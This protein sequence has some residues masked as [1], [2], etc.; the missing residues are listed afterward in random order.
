MTQPSEK[1]SEKDM[2]GPQPTTARD[3]PGPPVGA[4]APGAKTVPHI[5]QPTMPQCGP[6]E[7]A[8]G[9][10]ELI[11]ELGRGGMG[12]VY[13][14]RQVELNRT[15]AVKMI[16][17]GTMS[18]PAEVERFRIE[19]EAMARLQHANIV[20]VFEVGEV[21]GRAYYSMEYID[22]PSLA[23]KVTDGPLPGR[24]AARCLAIIARALHH[25]HRNGILH[26]DLKPSNILLD[27]EGMPHI[28]D[29]GLAKKLDTDSGQTRTG[30]VMGTPSYMPPEQAAGRVR[31]LGPRSDVYS[32]GAVLY[33]S[34]T[35]R[36]PFRAETALDTLLQVLERQAA[37][38]RL[39]NAK[40]DRDLET[41]CMKCLE[42]NPGDRYESAEA[43]AADLER[44]LRGESIA[45]RTFNVL[46][47][48][49]RTLERDHYLGEF[50]AWGTMLLIFAAIVF[51]EHL[52]VFTLTI[53]GPP[54]PKGWIMLARFAQFSS[55]GIVFWRHRQHT[56]LPTSLAERQ[57]WSIWIGYLGACM[58]V[59]AVQWALIHSGHI[60]DEL[61]A[62]PFWSALT[63]L[64]FFAMGSSYW[65]RCYTLG[66]GFFLLAL[67][68]PFKLEWV[69]LEY[70]LMWT[71]S[72][73]LIGLH[74]WRLSDQ[75]P[76][77]VDPSNA[78]TVAAPAV[79]ASA[80][81][82]RGTENSPPA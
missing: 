50:H 79:A 66:L 57:L 43:L 59:G 40:V 54:Y 34:L 78:I 68:M 18:S 62:Y 69:V 45:A 60:K 30:T 52:I 13:K 77:P 71:L 23:H 3:L 58:V 70:G 42:K 27:R 76:Q 47:R 72:L 63:G 9:G 56:L 17:S 14:A 16:L 82:S 73:A 75:R 38:P 35:G 4:E 41:I 36:P 33:E 48:I 20:Q 46:D 29:F 39:L 81:G 53:G 28:T 37:P 55:M 80:S 61:L 24:E 21:D 15:V 67:A 74:L 64:A 19:A 32:L 11:A 6:V 51:V 44:Y 10:Y 26:R 7:R 31:D 65:G 22:G 2:S 5:V 12:V 25:A 1:E 49:G 8:F